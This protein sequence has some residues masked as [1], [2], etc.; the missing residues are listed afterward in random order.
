MSDTIELGVAIDPDAVNRYVAD[1][2]LESA[3]GDALK[4]E[5][6]KAVEG[7]RSYNSP[8]KNLVASHIEREIARLLQE[9]YADQIA[10]VVRE[11]VTEQFT[12]DL[13]DKAFDAF[14]RRT[15]Q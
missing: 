1:R 7:L 11:K 9:Q 2:I 3:I 13:I 15:Y 14:A 8:F 5:I 6:D 4:K 12:A 10:Q